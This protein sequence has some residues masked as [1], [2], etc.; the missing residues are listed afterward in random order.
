MTESERQRYNCLSLPPNL[1]YVNSIV[2]WIVFTEKT[3]DSVRCNS[4]ILYICAVVNTTMIYILKKK[5]L[6]DS[7]AGEKSKNLSAH[8]TDYTPHRYMR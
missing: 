1:I 7:C 8:G 4:I 6:A 3:A 5:R 2:P